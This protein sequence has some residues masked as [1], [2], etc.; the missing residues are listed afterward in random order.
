MAS[1][2]ILILNYNGS[3]HLKR[4]LPSIIANSGNCQII[5][6]DN[7]STDNSVELIRNTFPEV[8]VIKLAKNYGYAGGYNK[9]IEQVHHDYLV[10]VNSD[11]EAT[12]GWSTGLIKELDSDRHIA[13]VQ[14][15]ILSFNQRHKF[16]Y[17]GAAGGY[18]DQYGYPFCRGRIFKTIEEDHGQ[19]DDK[20]DIFW[21]SGACLMVRRSVFVDLGG[22]DNDF[23]AHMEEIDLCW[24]MHNAGYRVVYSSDSLVYHLGGGTLSYQNPQKTY[25]NFRNGWVMLLKNISAPNTKTILFIRWLLD[26]LSMGYFLIQ[27]QPRNFAAIIKAHV[28]ILSKRQKIKQKRHTTLREVEDSRNMKPW[29]IS[30]VWQYY[31][32]Q[33][34]RFSD[35]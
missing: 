21:A 16:E 28:Y 26:V 25:L 18:I 17:A 15:K 8:K 10:L 1:V 34:K 22:F 31:L 2:A 14:P 12:P 4:F 11:I 5:V 3:D 20:T 35:L 23:F 13:A 7:N 30:I 24:R 32:K 33:K 29:A 19:Y 6:G 27:L 9:L